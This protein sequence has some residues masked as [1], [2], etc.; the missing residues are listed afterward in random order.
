[1]TPEAPAVLIVDDETAVRTMLDL[2]LQLH[3]VRVLLAA[4]GQEALVL[5]RCRGQE[6]TPWEG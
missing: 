6:T 5:Y 1:L 2:A 3:G 4:S